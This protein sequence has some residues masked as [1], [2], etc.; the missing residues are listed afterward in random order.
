[1]A[2]QLPLGPCLLSPFATGSG[3]LEIGG[4]AGREDK[5]PAVVGR[6]VQGLVSYLCG[7]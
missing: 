5:T 6:W 4:G 7:I 3:T 1:M 2:G